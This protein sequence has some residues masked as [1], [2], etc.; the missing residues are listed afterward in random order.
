MKTFTMRRAALLGTAA[1]AAL[2]VGTATAAEFDVGGGWSARLDSEVSTGFQVRTQGRDCSIVGR[3]NGGC[4]AVTS[5]L[6][7]RG[8]PGAVPDFNYLQYDSGDVN[9]DKG[10]LTS[11]VVKGTHDLSFKGPEEITVLMRGYWAADLAASRTANFGLAGD[12]EDVT[13]FDATLLDAWVS[14]GFSW[15]GHNAKIRV[16]NQVVSWGE[17]IFLYGGINVTNAVD[18]RKWHTPGTA[19]KEVLVPAPM[20]HLNT[21]LTEDLSAEAYYQFGWNGFKFDPVGTFLSSVDLLG[22]GSQPGFLPSVFGGVG[23]EHVPGAIPIPRAATNEPSHQGQFGF[24]LRYALGDAELGAYYIRYHDKVPSI[25]FAV[26]PASP[27]GLDY[28]EDYGEDRDL[29]GISGNMPVA[30]AF[31]DIVF[32]SELS[33]RP[34]DTVWIDPTLVAAGTPGQAYG[35]NAAGIGRGYI[36]EKKWQAHLTANHLFSP[37]S[38]LGQFQSMLGA[39]DG[40]FL[41]EIAAAYYPDLATDGSVPYLLPN[42]SLPDKLSAGYMFEVGMTFP[43]IFGTPINFTPFVDF[44]HDFAGT[45]PNG[46]Q[47]IEG[48]KSLALNLGFNYLGRIKGNIVYAAFL[49]GGDNNL[50]KDR[51]FVG[52]SIT[53]SF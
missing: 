37:D 34:R 44:S 11:W 6:Q 27:I 7:G 18:F 17:D 14:K 13:N 39:A 35:F 24:A 22:P 50:M 40:Y 2:G 4:A 32:G 12:A 28:F 10:D 1:A 3:D 47:F 41:G 30:T 21:E 38:P 20:V 51:D 23:D 16:G 48:R 29:F 15:A 31:G 8:Y 25:S 5:E 46:L 36:D 53:Y 33:Y 42:Y 52:A 45:T 49:D 19:L 9:Y 43:H 26:N